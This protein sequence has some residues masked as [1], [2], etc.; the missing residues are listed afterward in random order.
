VIAQVETVGWLAIATVAWSVLAFGAVYPWA[1]WPLIGISALTG[2]V[3]LLTSR[4]GALPRAFMLGIAA[5]VLTVAVQLIPFH[6]SVLAVLSPA[7]DSFLRHYNLEYALVVRTAGV[8]VPGWAGHPLSLSP[9]STARGLAFL[10][11]L[12]LLLAG[13]TASL[14]SDGLRPLVERITVLALAVAM[15][16]I[17][18]QATVTTGKVYGFWTPEQTGSIY[19]P[20]VN[21]NHFA[22]WMVMALALTIGLA[23]GRIARGM[24]GGKPGW[25]NRVLWLS[26][27]D[28][29][30]LVFTA[31]AALVMGVALALS[32]SRS[33]II[34]FA[35]AILIA[36][37]AVVKRQTTWHRRT[38]ATAYMMFVFIVAVAWA[39]VDV[40]A[41]RF[42]GPWQDVGGR[43][44][45]WQDALHMAG[46]FPL[47]GVGINA[48][49]EAMLDYQTTTLNVHFSAA[50][51]DW[52]QLAS[53][54]G[55]LVGIPILFALTLLIR[56]IARRFRERQDDAV[57]S[58]IRTGAVTGLV[59]IGIQEFFDFSLQIPGNAILFTVLAAIAIHKPAARGTPGRAP[60]AACS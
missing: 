54:G 14:S 25:R 16:G 42:I 55:L 10:G 3:G 49:G 44:G 35:A 58:S 38:V 45:V 46:D 4:Q 12:A 56:E 27:P 24:R 15:I 50:H 48:F 59:A 43:L 36:A 23:S 19:G 51:N 37:W 52:V 5:V 20:F 8:T 41:R 2:A 31:F 39:G 29:S 30:R 13:L 34:A 60:V 57:T 26:T 22:G 32:L 47:T 7:T 11:S 21:K 1:Y 28:A 6:Q 40:V 18:Q 33:G 53:E 17:I 9:V